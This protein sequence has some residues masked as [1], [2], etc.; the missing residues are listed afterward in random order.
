MAWSNFLNRYQHIQSNIFISAAIIALLQFTHAL[1]YMMI[2]PLFKYIS[3]DLGL[4]IGAAGYVTGAYTAASVVSGVISFLFI[5][6]L[7]KKTTL[8]INLALLGMI[9]AITP[10]SSGLGTLL[11]LR[12]LAGLVGGISLGIGL[13]LLLNRTP[14]EIRGRIIAIVVGAFS[15]VSLLG[16][17]LSLYLAEHLSWRLPF[18]LIAGICML[19]MPLISYCLPEDTAETITTPAARSL[20]LSPPL[21]LASVANAVANFAPFVMI[22][23]L[24][25][26]LINLTQVPSAKIP[27]VF[28]I[29]GLSSY[30]GTY[31]SGKLAD[32]WGALR[33][34]SVASLLFCITLLLLHLNMINGYWFM[35]LFMFSTYMRIVSSSV[36]SSYFPDN[37]HRAG[38]NQLQTAQTNLAATVAFFLPAVLLGNN[39]ISS[40]SISNILTLAIISGALLPPYL[41]A[42]NRILKPRMI[43]PSL[44]S[45]R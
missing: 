45:S 34:G 44:K 5:D 33:T 10:F 30:A 22:P 16:L 15:A 1:E 39:D 31:L 12:I 18:W 7:N 43:S 40:D 20:T 13:A 21:L 11:I 35:I 14:P 38:F 27:L 24:V 3:H 36:I 23:I 32:R 2:G 29:G 25:P 6:R 37:A 42:L 9:T 4:P 28:F 41:W 8:L 19:C 17:P 26:V